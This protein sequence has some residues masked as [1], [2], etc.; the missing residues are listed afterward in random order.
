MG[1]FGSCDIACA[2][3]RHRR[4]ADAETRPAGQLLGRLIRHMPCF[5]VISRTVGAHVIAM[6]I[7]SGVALL[8]TRVGRATSLGTAHLPAVRLPALTRSAD[9]EAGLAPLATVDHHLVPG[10]A[11]NLAAEGDACETARS[12]LSPG[13][14]G[15]QP[16]PSAFRRAA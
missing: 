10:G 8:V 7:A 9:D 6:V 1:S 5:Q 3:H 13:R 16:E 15:C 11:E 12:T 2:V 4:V 14:L